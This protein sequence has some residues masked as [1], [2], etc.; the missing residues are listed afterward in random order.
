MRAAS[1]HR[2]DHAV[3]DLDE[4]AAIGG[5]TTV[6]PFVFDERHRRADPLGG[7]RLSTRQADEAEGPKASGTHAVAPCQLPHIGI[8]RDQDCIVGLGRSADQLVGR[9]AGH[10]LCEI[11]NVMARSFEY[12]ADR[13]G[14]AFIEKQSQA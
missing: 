14:N 2:S 11:N 12:M 8:Q 9:A 7:A 3:A 4:D 6:L 10:T 13:D 5:S 1:S